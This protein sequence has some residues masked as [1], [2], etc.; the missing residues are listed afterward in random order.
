MKTIKPFDSHDS[1]MRLL[2]AWEDICGI[3]EIKV[4]H[5]KKDRAFLGGTIG[6]KH[7]YS[8]TYLLAHGESTWYTWNKTDGQQIHELKAPTLFIIEPNE[9]HAVIASNDMVLVG[10]LPQKFQPGSHIDAEHLELPQK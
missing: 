4:L 5:T 2:T 6:H 9:E 3:P 7:D 1:K 10:L 8:E